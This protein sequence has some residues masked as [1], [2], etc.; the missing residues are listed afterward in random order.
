MK[1]TRNILY[2]CTAFTAFAT[3]IGIS[4]SN[5]YSRLVQEL[6]VD[7]MQV[8]DSV[9]DTVHPDTAMYMDSAAFA[10]ERISSMPDSAGYTAYDADSVPA[11]QTLTDSLPSAD[12][13]G[14]PS[15]STAFS[16]T[17]SLVQD[18]TANL[19][20]KELRLLMK[21]KKMEEKWRRADSTRRAKDS[22][23]YIK[24]SIKASIPRILDTYIIP[25][26]MKYRRILSWTNTPRFNNIEL[27]DIDTGFNYHFSEYPFRKN[28]VDAVYQGVIGSATMSA[29]YFR[30]QENR[31]AYF[32]EPY[33]D[34]S[35]TPETLPYINTK[36]PY[37]ELAYWG[38]LFANMEK[39]EMDIK[40]LTSTNISPALNVTILFQRFG[41]NGMLKREDTDDRTFAFYGN[42]V[43]KRYVMHTGYLYQSVTKSENG[44]LKDTR[45]ITD[46][47]MDVRTI[48]VMLKEASNKLK[49]HTVF[50]NQTYGVPI[51][52]KK[53]KDTLEVKTDLASASQEDASAADRDETSGQRTGKDG[54]TAMGEGTATYFGHS[55]EFST[56]KKIYI[57]NIASNDEDGR[58]FYGERFYLHPTQ[59]YDSM[60]VMDFDNRLF[61]KV[62]PWKDDAIIS[63]IDAGAGYQ[64][65]N[66]Y[67]FDPFFYLGEGKVAGYHNLYAYAGVSGRFRKY[68]SWNADADYYFAGYRA[69]DFS[70]NA[71]ARISLYPIPKG[72]HLDLGFRLANQ[73]P[74]WYSNSFISNHY[75]WRNSFGKE[76]STRIT[77]TL[78]VPRYSLEAFVGYELT[79]NMIYF[80]Y[81]GTPKQAASPVSVLSAYLRKDFKIWNFHMDNRI[82][83]QLSSNKEAVPLPM[84]ALNLRWYFQFDVVKNVLQ[85]QIGVDGTFNTKYNMPAYN[86]VTGVF[87]SQDI[88]QTGNSPYL[89]F[90]IN[91]QWKRACIFV[92][93]VNASQQWFNKEYFS[94]YGYIKPQSAFK[95]GIYWPFYVH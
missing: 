6:A 90:F 8:G 76:T 7:T 44:G 51:R 78:T 20:K 71:N 60:T 27:H 14:F 24:D 85:A 5:P 40:F 46:T 41:S 75:R 93:Y 19:S 49:K 57:D 92:K 2:F 9:T 22:I 52:W 59:S 26:S 88:M 69:N 79:G 94:A 33:M 87:H 95:V 29:N 67:M 55:S 50:I 63:K 3:A 17:D 13:S 47:V 45:F 11:E 72:I 16:A 61:I 53:S 68:F 84:L 43:G 36:S 30:R 86:P 74:D 21:E 77:G 4:A 66:Y 12:S 25:D 89:D 35:Y 39:E 58:S 42:H 10:A 81:D 28:D 91:L 82:L 56:Y 34:Y 70:V 80:G 38:T 1:A 54:K 83:F 64:Y 18:S 62:Q 48:P 31:S 65:L 73:A 37:T 23:R 32:F 15:D